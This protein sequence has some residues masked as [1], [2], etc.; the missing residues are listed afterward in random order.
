MTSGGPNSCTRHD[1]R[2]VEHDRR[3]GAAGDHLA[4]HERDFPGGAADAEHLRLDL[5]EVPGSDRQEELDELEDLARR[6]DIP[7]GTLRGQ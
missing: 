6:N 1:G 7:P 4:R 3:A 5:D 2:R